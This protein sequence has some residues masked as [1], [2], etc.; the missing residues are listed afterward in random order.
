M[1][2]KNKSKGN[3]RISNQNKSY[4]DTVIMFFF[5]KTLYGNIKIKNDELF[6]SKTKKVMF[7]KYKTNKQNK[8]TNK[9]TGNS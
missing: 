4:C 3:S 2:R 9:L 8:Q 6:K 1:N 5:Q 7:T